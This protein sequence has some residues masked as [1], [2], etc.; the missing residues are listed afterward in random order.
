MLDWLKSPRNKHARELDAKAWYCGQWSYVTL[1]RQLRMHWTTVRRALLGLIRKCSLDARPVWSLDG[2]GHRRVG[3]VYTIP[4][5]G[6][7]LERRRALPDVAITAVGHLLCIGRSRRIMTKAEAQEW[8]IDLARAPRTYNERELPAPAPAVDTAAASEGEQ[9]AAPAHGPPAEEGA[10]H[11]KPQA[12]PLAILKAFRLHVAG[13]VPKGD[14]EHLISAARQ[15]AAGR[16]VP[17]TDEDI[18]ECIHAGAAAA[19]K[20]GV[21]SIRFYRST[22]P[23][24]VN[25]LLDERG[26]RIREWK[27]KGGACPLCRDA[28]WRMGTVRGIPQEVRCDCTPLE[29]F[30]QLLEHPPDH[31]ADMP[32]L[33]T[34]PTLPPPDPNAC[35]MCHGEGKR[36]Y[37][38]D[39]SDCGMCRGSGR[40]APP[41][42]QRA[43]G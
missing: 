6:D 5:Y 34:L 29:R 24:K 8:Q 3:T 33:P 38:A 7:A 20:K 9:A 4:A 1:A 15:I 13:M 23:E 27:D 2:R 28:G 36:G 10:M 21:R 16:G 30:K 22:L 18:C 12:V 19:G 25:A 14:A 17:L 11:Q 42:R 32:T 39:R 31:P 26:D 41:S 43:A 37:G 35:P 40:I